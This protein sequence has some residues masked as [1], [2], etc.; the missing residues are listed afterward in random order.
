MSR[1]PSEQASAAALAAPPSSIE[2]AE[3]GP[4]RVVG[5]GHRDKQPGAL[6]RAPS[7]RAPARGPVLGYRRELDGLR[8]FAVIIVVV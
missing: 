7:V 8:G 6:T 5:L 1:D 3:K 2:I 4:S